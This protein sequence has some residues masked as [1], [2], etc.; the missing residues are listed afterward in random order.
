MWTECYRGTG[1]NRYGNGVVRRREDD[2]SMMMKEIMELESTV[3]ILCEQRNDSTHIRAIH[4]V[5]G[6]RSAGLCTPH[7]EHR[8]RVS[9]FHV[10]GIIWQTSSRR[11]QAVTITVRRKI[12]NVCDEHMTVT[13]IDGKYSVV[14]TCMEAITSDSFSNACDHI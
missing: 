7:V 4:I 14:C 11:Q 13:T 5:R 12:D 10:V 6:G 3:H 9:S 2:A 1:R 8:N